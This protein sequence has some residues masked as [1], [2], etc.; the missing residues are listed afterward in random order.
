[1]TH[2]EL[3]KAVTDLLDL[4]GIPYSVT[5]ASR[6][7][8]RTG[9][10]GKP[11]VKRGWPDI[12]LVIPPHG[13]AA[14]IELKTPYDVLRSGQ[15]EILDLLRNAGAHYSVAR[16]VDDV[17]DALHDWLEPGTKPFSKLERVK[18]APAPPPQTLRR[19]AQ[20]THNRSNDTEP[21]RNPTPTPKVQPRALKSKKDSNE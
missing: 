18:I 16:S 1:M 17:I 5:D 21:T 13:Q 20:T 11:K 19:R 8:T 15:I 3:E 6:V 9:R 7:W 4:L 14:F 12:S 10:V 2:A